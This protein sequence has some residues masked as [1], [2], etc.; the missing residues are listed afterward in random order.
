MERISCDVLVV[1][2][3]PGG[4]VA[5]IRAAQLGLDTVIVEKSRTGGTCLNVG[6]VPSKALIHAADEFY[7]A[8]GAKGGNSIGVRIENPSLD[9]SK[10]QSWK[11]GVVSGLNRGVDGLLKKSGAK[12][13]AGAGRMVD[14]KTCMVETDNG[15]IRIAAKNVIL[16]PGSVPVELP[17]LPFTGAVISSTE[18]LSLER[19]PGKLAVVG[20]GYIGLE[21]GIAFAK[22][23]SEVA[24][25]EATGQLLPQYDEALSTP[26]AKRLKDLGIAVHL[27]SRARGIVEDGAKLEFETEG[28]GTSQIAVEKVL[29]TVGRKPNLLGWGLEELQLDTSGDRILVDETCKTSMTGVYAIGD[30]TGE[31]M[32]AHRAMAQAEVA[33]E[34]IAGKNRVFDPVSIPAI[35][36][37]DPE[38]ISVGLLPDEAE[39]S[40]LDIVVATF[41]LSANS[42]AMTLESRSG[43]VRVVARKDNGLVLGIQATG[44]QI[45]ELSASFSLA[46]E[47]GACLE[48]IARTIHVHP[49]Q[50]EAFPEAA[51]MALGRG[52]HI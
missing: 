29:V 15:D 42:R 1:G 37:T 34:V 50:S 3:G 6:C 12:L 47:M 35:C 48:D 33:A 20:G 4:Y 5:A 17:G 13:V 41:P 36:F 31:P 18:A 52:L 27:S 9:W 23:G 10:T 14:G 44:K 22:F 8:V 39:K 21:L 24:I 38:I 46:L 7:A 16:A 11:D 49:T 28:E 30:V 25:I 26:V 2:A 43:F 32:L 45:S 51:M 19:V 40:G